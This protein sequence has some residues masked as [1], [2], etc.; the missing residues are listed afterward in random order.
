MMRDRAGLLIFTKPHKAIKFWFETGVYRN[1]TAHDRSVRFA[2]HAT[3]QQ[4]NLARNEYRATWFSIRG[5]SAWLFDLIEKYPVL[6]SIVGV[7][8]VFCSRR[9]AAQERRFD[10]QTER[11][12]TVFTRLCAATEV[13]HC[14]NL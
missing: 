7:A 12:L 10:P 9:E 13:D 8:H 3:K 1:V 2:F 6:I 4:E 5:E 11:S 14:E